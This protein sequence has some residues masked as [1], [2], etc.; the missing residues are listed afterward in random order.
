MNT[1]LVVLAVFVF[2]LVFLYY[3][4]LG[5]YFM[6]QSNDISLSLLQLVL[7]RFRKV[8]PGIIVHL[9]VKAKSAGI[10][11]KPDLLEACYLAGGDV[12]EFVETAISAKQNEVEASVNEFMKRGLE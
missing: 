6:C 11:I 1:F 3:V 12:Y 4:P 8:P 9:L 7:M 2:F 5:L 10:I